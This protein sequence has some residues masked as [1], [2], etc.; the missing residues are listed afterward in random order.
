[1]V[2]SFNEI[3][4]FFPVVPDHIFIVVGKNNDA[5]YDLKTQKIYQINHDAGSFLLNCNGKITLYD[6]SKDLNLHHDLSFFSFCLNNNIIQ[7]S[8]DSKKGVLSNT[9]KIELYTKI[10][11]LKEVMLEITTNCNL[12]CK[13]CYLNANSKKYNQL[14]ID[15]IKKIITNLSSFDL[16]F[17]GLTGG[18]PFSHPKINEILKL[19]IDNNYD[20]EILTNGTMLDLKK[21]SNLENNNITL[22]I[23]LLGLSQNT[24]DYFT[25][26]KGSF[27]KTLNSIK[28]CKEKNI[29]IK[30]NLIKNKLNFKEIETRLSDFIKLYDLDNN[31]I[32]IGRIIPMGRGKYCNKFIK[33][34]RQVGINAYLNISKDY[35]MALMELDS[36][37]LIA[38]GQCINLLLKN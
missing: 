13:H 8:K 9:D 34:E 14:S 2:N 25:E 19:L 36:G 28:I 22:Y 30:I 23:S 26:T 32:Q 10:P 38:T 11:K 24:H 35:I 7:L 15:N 16:N 1:M 12:H 6:L 5:I 31:D 21:T 17:I 18:E 27:N 20:I 4:D 3:K 33:N 37:R 29:Q